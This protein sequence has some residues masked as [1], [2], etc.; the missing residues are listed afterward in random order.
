MIQVHDAYD[1]LSAAQI[2]DLEARSAA[3]PFNVQLVILG[4]G[5]SKADLQAKV[6]SMVSE[7][8]LLA[9][10]IAPTHHFTYVKGSVDLGLPSGP[11]VASA[12]NRFFRSGDLVSG[13]DAIAARAMAVRTTSHITQSQTGVPIVIQERHTSA[14]VWWL[15]GGVTALVI[16]VAAYLIWRNRRRQLEHE[17]NEAELAMEAAE[18]RSRN[19][20]EASWNA[21]LAARTS[22]KPGI[23]APATTSYAA[24]SPLRSVSTQTAVP[25]TQPTVIVQSQSSGLDNLLAFELGTMSNRDRVIEREREVIYVEP[26]PIISPTPDSGSSSSWGGSDSGSSSSWG[27]SDDSSSSSDSGG[28]WGGSDSGGGSDW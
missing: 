2:H 27:G 22:A 28:S 16:A 8:H 20:D 19:L 1:V 6:S 7:P 4:P 26:T 25:V 5:A 3:Y 12:G 21:R 10:G 24:P 17:A 18:L 13:I 15:L 9:I 23:P 11:D 14:G